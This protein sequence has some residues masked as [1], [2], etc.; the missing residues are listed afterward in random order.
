MK[1]EWLLGAQRDKLFS[2]HILSSILQPDLILT[3]S[4]Y[5]T[6]R[7]NTHIAKETLQGFTRMSPRI[8]KYSWLSVPIGSMPWI[9]P[10]VDQKHPGEKKKIQESS[11]KQNI[12]FTLYLQLFT[13]Y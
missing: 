8:S 2:S 12:A 9:Q 11:P 7:D 10:T 1:S 3:L 6:R 4:F 5:P 13:L